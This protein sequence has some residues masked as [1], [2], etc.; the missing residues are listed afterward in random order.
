MDNRDRADRTHPDSFDSETD[1]RGLSRRELL[2]GAGALGVTIAIPS[3]AVSGGVLSEAGKAASAAEGESFRAFT[4]TEAAALSAMVARL[5]PRDENGPGAIEAGVPRYIDGLLRSDQNTY[6]GPNNPD[7]NLTDA[8]AAG[9]KA[10]DAYAQQAHAAPFASLRPV[11]QDALLTEMQANRAPGFTPDSRTFFNLV[12]R[13]AIEGMFGDPYYGGNVNFA[14]WDLIGYPGIKLV[15]TE[16]EQKLD[17]TLESIHKGMQDYPL[18][19]G[20]KKGM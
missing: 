19:A 6:H 9:L 12:R 17:A 15:F 5:I 8:Y 3:G 11:D 14:G 1:G 16:E 13:H 20:S 18:F 10:I 2:K 7:Q 4:V